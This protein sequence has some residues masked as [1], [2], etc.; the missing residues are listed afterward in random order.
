MGYALG[1][2]PAESFTYTQPDYTGLKP[3]LRGTWQVSGS[4]GLYHE[5]LYWVDKN[6]P[7]GPAPAN[8]ASDPQYTRWDYAVQHWLNTNYTAPQAQQP[9]TQTTPS[10]D[11]FAPQ[12]SPSGGA[13]VPQ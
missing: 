11:P 6:N 4:D 2:I 10:P 3:V 5:I 13:V 7:L 9:Q 12:Y 8:P 1:K